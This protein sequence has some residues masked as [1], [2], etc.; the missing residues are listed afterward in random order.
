MLS[1]GVSASYAAVGPEWR[2]F[3]RRAEQWGFSTLYVADHVGMLDPFVALTAAAG[4]SNHLALGTY[5]L[6][7][8]FWNPLLLARSAATLDLLS[9]GRLVLGLGAGHAEVEFRQAG[10]AYPAPA[11]RVTK[12]ER[13]VDVLARLLGGETVDDDRLGLAGAG[14]GIPPARPQVPILIGGNGRRVLSLAGRSADVAGIV[15]FRS[16]TGQVHTDLSHWTWDGLA[17]RIDVV[18]TAAEDR[19]TGPAFDLLVQRVVVT[20]DREAAAQEL[21]QATGRDAGAHLASPFLLL[22]TEEE[23]AAQ[24]QRLEA[25]P[26]VSAITVFAPY[27]EV[28]APII[29]RLGPG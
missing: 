24:L 2:A 27:A 8:E 14:T 23:I 3:I 7:I 5:V 16:G 22:G 29:E 20:G 10:L 6:N 4:E 25:E 12:L 17:D 9:E 13:T 19:L 21:A 28:L 15:G 18:R 11:E 1:F 26:G